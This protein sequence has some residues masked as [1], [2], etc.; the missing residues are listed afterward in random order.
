[1]VLPHQTTET[2][3]MQRIVQVD[4]RNSE[5]V[6][7]RR[8]IRL[9]CGSLV[10]PHTVWRADLALS[11]NTGGMASPPSPTPGPDSVSL[12]SHDR[13]QYLGDNHTEPN[14]KTSSIWFCSSCKLFLLTLRQSNLSY[15]FSKAH[16]SN[17]S[18]PLFTV[19]LTY[20]L[21]MFYSWINWRRSIQHV[22]HYLLYYRD[23]ESTHDM[24]VSKGISQ[25]LVW[26]EHSFFVSL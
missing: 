11:N 26:K 14:M 22:R 16:S 8:R 17:F 6:A 19:F 5:V 23:I 20:V 24:F 13:Q 25:R 3:R 7:S 4:L 9:Y 18:W 12:M 2:Q 10:E 21:N 1:M 15:Y